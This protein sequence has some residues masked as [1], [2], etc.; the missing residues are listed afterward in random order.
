M[1]RNS[2]FRSAGMS[3]PNGPM[4]CNRVAFYPNELA[5]LPTK[6]W[7]G[8]MQSE[9]MMIDVIAKPQRQAAK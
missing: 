2:K 7:Q 3:K 4:T 5:S 1:P 8:N 9:P 6:A